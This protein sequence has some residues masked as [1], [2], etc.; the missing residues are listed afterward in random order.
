MS[1][2]KYGKVAYSF[3]Y[4]QGVEYGDQ[5]APGNMGDQLLGF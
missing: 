1:D 3:R 4:S 2:P 5:R